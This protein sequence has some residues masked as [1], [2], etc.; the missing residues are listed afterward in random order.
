[1]KI[2]YLRNNIYMFPVWVLFAVWTATARLSRAASAAGVA[3]LELPVPSTGGL[4][5]AGQ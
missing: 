2:D 1:M 5:A 4:R 3:P